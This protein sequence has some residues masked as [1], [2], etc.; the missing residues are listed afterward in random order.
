MKLSSRYRLNSRRFK[1]R[2]ET[3]FFFNWFYSMDNKKKQSKT[4][5]NTKKAQPIKVKKAE[6]YPKKMTVTKK[7]VLVIF[8]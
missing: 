4:N 5:A 1:M 3:P 7:T 8:D 2:K 6:V